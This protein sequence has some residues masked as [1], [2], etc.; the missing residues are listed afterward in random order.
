MELETGTK[1]GPYRI[2]SKMADGGMATLYVA[3]L[4]EHYRQKGMPRQVVLKVAKYDREDFLKEEADHLHRLDHPGIVRI[5]PLPARRGEDLVGRVMTSAGRRPYLALEYV[6]GGTLE[7]RLTLRGPLPVQE[8]I[9]I[10]IQLARA[11][12]HAHQRGLLNRDVKPGNVLLRPAQGLPGTNKSKVVLC[13]FGIAHDMQRPR[14]GENKVGT[15]GYMSPEQIQRLGNEAVRLEPASD[16]YSLGVVLYEMLT[17]RTPFGENMAAIVDPIARP[18]PPSS[19]R[20]GIPPELDRIVMQALEKDPRKRFQTAR[21]LAEALRRLPYQVD[22]AFVLPRFLAVACLIGA[23]ILA[24]RLGVVLSG[25]DGPDETPAVEA[26]VRRAL[27]TEAVSG[28]TPTA[29][30]TFTDTAST[31]TAATATPLTES[32]TPRPPTSTPI[33]PTPTFTP[34]PT[35]T[36]SP[37]LTPTLTTTGSTQEAGQ[38]GGM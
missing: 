27:P 4:R 18:T 35:H 38:E 13:D 33:T 16:V 6:G 12:E 22:L 30:F 36:P 20:R 19:L 8:A 14:A 11:L 32:P 15:F 7:E 24:W 31:A 1:V 3:E 25:G 23:V 37:T 2:L 26:T 28:G 29:P 5:Y 9:Q 34:T 10:G 21:E 17:G